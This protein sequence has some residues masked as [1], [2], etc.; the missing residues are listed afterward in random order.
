[1]SVITLEQIFRPVNPQN[2]FERGK[3]YILLGTSRVDRPPQAEM[4]RIYTQAIERNF[5][6]VDPYVTTLRLRTVKIGSHSNWY[7]LKT[8]LRVLWAKNTYWDE[9]VGYIGVSIFSLL[10]LASYMG[11]NPT[12]KQLIFGSCYFLFAH[13]STLSI[14]IY[15][16]KAIIKQIFR[17]SRDRFAFLLEMNRVP[18]SLSTT[19]SSLSNEKGEDPIT[20]QPL[21]PNIFAPRILRIGTYA[22]DIISALRSM[23]GKGYDK[24]GKIPHP[25]YNQSLSAEEQDKFL[26]DCCAFFCIADRNA[27]LSCWN[28]HP[29]QHN[30]ER[31]LVPYGRRL[32]FIRLLPPQIAAKYFGEVIQEMA[33]FSR[34]EGYF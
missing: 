7:L 20:L 6:S 30:F 15:V 24:N 16:K 14:Y 8:I 28:D 25:I 17:Q 29:L 22:L 13:L 19:F 32:K 31:E 34:Y 23:L 4:T 26:T 9:I 18:A 12:K 27:L 3:R 11:G 33:P 5:T 2:D 1:M 10:P 21:T